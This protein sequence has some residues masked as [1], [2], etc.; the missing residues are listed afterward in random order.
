MRVEQLAQD[1]PDFK[2]RMRSPAPGSLSP[3]GF[4]TQTPT[5]RGIHAFGVPWGQ[6][7]TDRPSVIPPDV[8]TSVDGRYLLQEE[9]RELRGP[10]GTGW[11]VITSQAAAS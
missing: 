6:L 1:K 10:T 2:M 11:C 3:R 9:E 4:G 7:E 5:F 8:R